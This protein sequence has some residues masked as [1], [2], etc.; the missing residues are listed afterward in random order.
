MTESEG[1]IS[2]I[3][4][5]EIQRLIP[6]RYPFLLIDKLVDI[7]LGLKAT[8]I[9]NVTM[10]EWFFQGHFPEKPI[11]PGVLIVEAMAQAAGA[12]VIKTLEQQQGHQPQK[13]RSVF[14]MSIEEAKFRKP[15]FPGDTLLLKVTFV[16][17]KGPVW[18]FSGQAWVGE[19]LMDEATFTAMITDK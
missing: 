3:N 18:K 16:K 6:H 19:Q 13:K 14:F 8:G 4:I 1:Y 17:S 5:D 7:Q 11:M 12:L 10:N 9:K 15:V 2:E